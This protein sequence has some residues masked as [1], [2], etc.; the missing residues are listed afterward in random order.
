[1]AKRRVR[2]TIDPNEIRL[3][4]LDQQYYGPEPKYAEGE[5]TEDNRKSL[6]GSALN[7]Y[8][9]ILDTKMFGLQKC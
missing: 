4:D 8:S 6:L 5:V 1:M 9:K 3:S 7:W 2:K